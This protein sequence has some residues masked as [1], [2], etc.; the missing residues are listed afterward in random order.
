MTFVREPN[1]AATIVLIEKAISTCRRWQS[2]AIVF[3]VLSVVFV[4]LRI[5]ARKLAPKAY[6]GW[7]DYLIIG[8]ALLSN[9]AVCV[10]AIC[11]Y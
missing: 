8:P 1:V 10:S 5:L 3:L 11:K 9:I 6:W 2:V 7:D 4:S